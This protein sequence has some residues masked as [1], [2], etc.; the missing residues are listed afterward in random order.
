MFCL[1]SVLG[2]KTLSAPGYKLLWELEQASAVHLL[3]F[4]HLRKECCPFGQEKQS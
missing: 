2:E 4:G 1:G 3:G